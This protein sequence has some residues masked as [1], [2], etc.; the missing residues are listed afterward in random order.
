[1]ITINRKVEESGHS[2]WF[3][4]GPLL[5]EL[6]FRSRN[7]FVTLPPI[8]VEMAGLRHGDEG[9]SSQEGHLSSFRIVLLLLI[10]FYFRDLSSGLEE[11]A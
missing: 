6:N 3:K 9:K 11:K 5:Q 10:R 1:M 2:I 4:K 8:L 7:E